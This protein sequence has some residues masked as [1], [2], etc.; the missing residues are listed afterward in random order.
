[1]KKDFKITT[2]FV[3]GLLVAAIL[4]CNSTPGRKL[5]D[6]MQLGEFPNSKLISEI[7]LVESKQLDEIEKQFGSL[8]GMSDIKEINQL[9]YRIDP[10]VEAQQIYEFFQ[11]AIEKQGWQTITSSF[12]KSKSTGIFYLENQGVFILTIGPQGDKERKLTLIR[13]YGEVEPSKI[14]LKSLPGEIIE[15]LNATSDQPNRIP[16]GQTISVPPSEKLYII[17]TG[18]NINAQIAEGNTVELDLGPRATDA[19]KL[20]RTNEVLTLDLEPKANIES[21]T[22]PSAVPVSFKLTD[23]SL[24]IRSDFF[25]GKIAK[26]VIDSTGAPILIESLPLIAGEHSLKVVGDRLK[27]DVG[28]SKVE[29]GTFSIDTTGADVTLTLP[30][31]ASAKVEAFTTSGNIEN[32]TNATAIESSKDSLKLQFGDGKAVISLKAVKGTVCIKS[33]F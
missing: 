28:F 19:G 17:S 20:I 24:T 10:D 25:Q 15:A 5:L 26:L 8:F 6:S 1:M 7:N 18:S 32:L 27:V 22:I 12:G 14:G 3:I 21:I 2:V 30:K 33:G 4:P 9:I 13:I 11:L 16:I 23:G 31:K 29:G